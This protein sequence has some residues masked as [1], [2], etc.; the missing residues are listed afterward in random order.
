MAR[1]NQLA[2]MS[3]SEEGRWICAS[4]GTRHDSN[5]KPCRNCASEQFAKLEEPDSYQIDETQ[6]VTWVCDSCGRESPRNNTQCRNCGS[7]S[8]SKKTESPDSKTATSDG[9]Q[10]GDSGS[11]RT[12]SLSLIMAYAGGVLAI[13]N[14]LGALAILHLSVFLFGMAAAISLPPLK[15]RVQSGLG[16]TLTTAATVVLYV[17]LTLIGNIWYFITGV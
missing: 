6:S 16:I 8:Y 3:E 14:A 11:S 15:R 13:L 10:H 7:F 12:V 5:D 1:S 2:T 9:T 17:T 4:C